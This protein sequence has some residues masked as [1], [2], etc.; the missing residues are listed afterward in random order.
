MK[1]EYTI[2]I[3]GVFYKAG[4]ELPCKKEDKIEETK[5]ATVEK[6]DEPPIVS[7]PVEQKRKYTRR[8]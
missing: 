2:K 6:P 4:D 7:E 8:K 1:A 5:A 3:D